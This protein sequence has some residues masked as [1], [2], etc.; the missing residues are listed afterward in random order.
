MLREPASTLAT[1]GVLVVIA[2]VDRHTGRLTRPPEV[3]SHGFV[4]PEEEPALLEAVAKLGPQLV[5]SVAAAG[6]PADA[7]GPTCT[8]R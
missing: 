1:D 4:G 8:S 5:D 2:A 6:P 7:T 3:M